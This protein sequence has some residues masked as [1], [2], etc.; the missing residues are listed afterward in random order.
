MRILITGT[1]GFIGGHLVQRLA[2]EHELYALQRRPAAAPVAGVRYVQQDLALPLD[3]RQLPRQLDAVIHQA[4]LI[5]TA[6]ADDDS[7]PFLVNVVASWRLLQYAR[8]AGASRFLHAS[9]GGIYGSRER[10]FVES[11]Q[12][13]P[14]DLYAL[15]K[16]QAELAVR[17]E[18]YAMRTVILRYFF[19]YGVGTPNPMPRY[20]RRAVRGEP[21]EVLASGAP[22]LNPLH[23]SDAVV[24]TVRALELDESDVINVAG[25]QVTSFA[26]IATL[27][28]RRVGREPVF[29][30]QSEQDA[31]PYYRSN[32]LADIARMQQRLSFTPR[33][34]LEDGLVELV[35]DSL[36]A[37]ALP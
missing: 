17:S 16:A 18:S 10:A 37:S 1:S 35:D 26:D 13:N 14:M 29:V 22:R 24:A 5:D 27:A 9:T 30:K 20:V 33:V 11:D 19:P 31:I 32:V 25:T 28:A 7:L 12:P 4:A 8:D 6:A 23:I 21:I 15:T 2:G 36:A 3:T 34:L